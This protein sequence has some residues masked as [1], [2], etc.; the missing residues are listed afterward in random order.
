MPAATA[1]RNLPYPLG[2]D[3]VTDGDDQIRKLAQSVENM[4]QTASVVIPVAATNTA[5]NFVWV[6]PIPFSAVPVVVATLVGGVVSSGGN[7][8]IAGQTTT[9]VTI[10]GYRTSGTTAITAQVI[11]VGPV[12]PVS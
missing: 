2:T 11:A 5:T 8:S 12:T 1:G 9:Q 6:Y 7:L 3:R 10:T 4:I